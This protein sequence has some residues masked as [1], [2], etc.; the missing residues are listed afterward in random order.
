M[1]QLINNLEDLLQSIDGLKAFSQF[2]QSEGD[3]WYEA[4]QDYVR[5]LE[6]WAGSVES[7][8]RLA[9]Q[10]E[11]LDIWRKATSSEITVGNVYDYANRLRVLLRQIIS[12]LKQKYVSDPD[13]AKVANT[14]PNVPRGDNL[15]QAGAPFSVDDID[16]LELKP[17]VFGI[18]VNLNHLVKRLL[19]WVKSRKSK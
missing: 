4:D 19:N 18:G 5:K 14:F 13:L 7:I 9:G 15:K 12:T 6:Q 11:Y 16:V 8:L 2:L 1:K 10:D 3:E 17:N